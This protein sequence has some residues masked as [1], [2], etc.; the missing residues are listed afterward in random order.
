MRRKEIVMLERYFVFPHTVDRIREAWI[1]E[2]IERYVEHLAEQGYAAGTITEFHC[3]SSLASSP[4][5]RERRLLRN[6]RRMGRTL[7]PGG[8]GHTAQA[9][10]AASPVRGSQKRFAVRLN[11]SCAW[12]FMA[13][14]ATSA[15][16]PRGSRSP[17]RRPGFSVI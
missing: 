13:S 2:P 7:L 9:G 15:D 6:C 17:I 12:L 8:L 14:P 4:A 1:G 10:A 11:S 16:R 3:W 5:H